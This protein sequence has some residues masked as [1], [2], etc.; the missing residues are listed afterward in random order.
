M[1]LVAELL[2][3]VVGRYLVLRESAGTHNQASEWYRRWTTN[4]GV[5]W[6]DRDY[7]TIFN[8][9]KLLE[10]REHLRKSN[11]KVYAIYVFE[12]GK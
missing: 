3:Q 8:R 2:P 10:K 12:Q 11:G 9:L 7:A 5:H 4:P 6:F 1:A